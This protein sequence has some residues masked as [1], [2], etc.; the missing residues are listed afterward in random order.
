MRP[1][2]TVYGLGVPLRSPRSARASRARRADSPFRPGMVEGARPKPRPFVT[3]VARAISACGGT[4]PGSGARARGAGA[5]QDRSA[6][7]RYPPRRPTEH[8]I[9]SAARAPAELS[10]SVTSANSLVDGS[11]PRLSCSVEIELLGDA[12]TNC[13][14]P[15]TNCSARPTNCSA[16]A[17]SVVSVSVSDRRWSR[18]AR[19]R[20]AG[21][22]TVGE[23]STWSAVSDVV[24]RLR[25]RGGSTDVVSE[26]PSTWSERT[27]VGGGSTCRG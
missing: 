14:A 8:L 2:A 1:G 5:L 20:G 7:A 9:R 24:V 13:S 18:G 11:L 26:A 10:D 6:A 19:R 3:L 23:A 25:R 27:R 12:P 22:Q 16:T 4:R 21:R 17:D 15:P